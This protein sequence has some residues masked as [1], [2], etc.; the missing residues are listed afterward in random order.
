[1]STSL[2]SV[3]PG[4]K[5]LLEREEQP[6]GRERGEP[7]DELP[8]AEVLR[9]AGELH[10]REHEHR[11][12]RREADVRL[13]FELG[14]VV[15]HRVRGRPVRE[16]LPPVQPGIGEERVVVV[17]RVL[18][19][20]RKPRERGE[21]DGADQVDAH[22]EHEASARRIRSKQRREGPVGRGPRLGS[23]RSRGR[24]RSRGRSGRRSRSFSRGRA[25]ARTSGLGVSLA[26]R[27]AFSLSFGVG[28][29]L[30][31]VAHRGRATYHRS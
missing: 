28:V 1:M 7:D 12:Q 15:V 29:C 20:P 2:L 30:L 19:Q 6:C 13:A 25:R 5:Q 21:D 26:G 17:L 8:V 14:E 18:G 31:A 9:C 3:R 22:G 16:V 11:R 23:L 24:G 4:A 10:E 27:R